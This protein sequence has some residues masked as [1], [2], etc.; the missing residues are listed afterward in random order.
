MT[1]EV[2]IVPQFNSKVTRIIYE[3]G[4]VQAKVWL[5]GPDAQPTP[6]TLRVELYEPGASGFSLGAMVAQ[7][8]PGVSWVLRPAAD[9][10][11]AETVVL[12]LPRSRLRNVRVVVSAYCED[13]EVNTL[14]AR[15]A[16]VEYQPPVGVW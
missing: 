8:H 11:S 9:E 10:R 3:D 1:A 5:S 2:A 6:A 15:Q 14:G 7:A 16:D 13:P 4:T 12:P